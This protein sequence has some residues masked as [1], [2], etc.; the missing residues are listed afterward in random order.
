MSVLII[1]KDT[2]YCSAVAKYF[3][4]HYSEDVLIVTCSSTSNI[5]EYIRNNNISIILA[6][7]EFCGEASALDVKCAV[8]RLV[9]NKEEDDEK[10]V[11]KYISAPSLYNELLFI[12]SKYAADDKNGFGAAGNFIAFISVNGCGATTLSVG[13]AKRLA[14]EG[15]KVLYLGLDG[16]SDYCS[17]FSSE[18]GRGLSDII[19]ALKSKSGSVSMVA[20][21]ATH[22]GEVCF[23]DKCRC[24]DDICE[25]DDEETSILFSKI[26]SSDNYDAV[27]ADISFA[28][29]NVW[30]YVAKNAARIFC[31]TSNKTSAIAKTNNFI[32]TVKIRD[33]RNNTDSFSRLGVIVNRCSSG[34]PAAQISCERL[35]FIQRYSADDYTV[36]TSK[37]SKDEAWNEFIKG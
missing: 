23:I 33:Y 18:Q 19:L 1:S 28:N 3:R 20:K 22:Q 30:K 12:Y 7:E 25:V 35:V 31:V 26:I 21:S 29:M 10:S 14:A 17:I 24:A 2:D 15:K 27:V 5:N 13:Y 36:L 4:L 37:I 16:L 8:C 32:E 9:E 34:Q 11:C 6:D